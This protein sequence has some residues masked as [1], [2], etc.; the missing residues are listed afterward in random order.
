MGGAIK[1]FRCNASQDSQQATVITSKGRNSRKSYN[2]IIKPGNSFTEQFTPK[3]TNGSK[4]DL[5]QYSILYNSIQCSIITYPVVTNF[6]YAYDDD[7]S[8]IYI[9]YLYYYHT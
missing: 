1:Y 5:L 7:A 6:I 2:I 8:T 9:L 4:F 3:A